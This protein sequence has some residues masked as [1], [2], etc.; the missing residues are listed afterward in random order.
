MMTLNLFGWGRKKLL[1][2]VATIAV[3]LGI[4]NPAQAVSLNFASGSWLN[5]IGGAGLVNQ[6][7]E[8]ETQ[9]RWGTPA[10]GG[11]V[12][13]KSGL[14]F[15]GVSASALA[16]GEIF[17]LGRLRHFNHPILAGTAA[18]T[19]TLKLLL[20]LGDPAWSQAFDL[21]LAI[22]E[23]PNVAGNCTYFSV[24]PCADRIAFSNA[25]LVQNFAFA[26][27]NYT[28]HLLGFR[29]QGDETVVN[30]FISQ[31]GGTSQA[32]LFAKITAQTPAAP[33]PEPTTLA[34]AGFAL[35]GTG[36]ASRFKKGK[37]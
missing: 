31:E 11:G 6:S 15:T 30:E 7:V 36:L 21:N 37:S 16:L 34:G 13:L 4:N 35:L 17:Q 14:G 27:V 32:F 3:V 8:G 29:Q 5:P 18:S 23:T 20:N 2:T 12:D 19:I 9:I 33:V 26:G 22:E 1:T 10:F 25:S 28:L 24:A